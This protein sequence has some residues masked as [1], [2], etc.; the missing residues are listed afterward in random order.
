MSITANLGSSRRTTAGRIV[1]TGLTISLSFT[2]VALIVMFCLGGLFVG[3]ISLVVGLT[4]PETT[5]YSE[6]IAYTGYYTSYNIDYPNPSNYTNFLQYNESHFVSHDFPLSGH[7]VKQYDDYDIKLIQNSGNDG[8]ILPKYS[9]D[10]INHSSQIVDG[11]DYGIGTNGIMGNIAQN[12]TTSL[13]DSNGDAGNGAYIDFENM[14]IEHLEEYIFK[15]DFYI[16]VSDNTPSLYIGLTAGNICSEKFTI[17]AIDYGNYPFFLLHIDSTRIRVYVYNN[18]ASSGALVYDSGVIAST[19]EKWYSLSVRHWVDWDN[20][21]SK[22]IDYFALNV[23]SPSHSIDQNFQFGSQLRAEYLGLNN[24]SYAPQ[25]WKFFSYDSP[26]VV[27]DI[28]HGGI[29]KTKPRYCRG[30]SV[31]YSWFTDYLMEQA[32]YIRPIYQ[33][34]TLDISTIRCVG[35]VGKVV[36]PSDPTKEFL[37]FRIGTI[38]YLDFGTYGYAYDNYYHDT[39]T[40]DDLFMASQNEYHP[41]EIRALGNY[42]AYKGYRA[43]LGVVYANFTLNTSDID[44]Y[45]SYNGVTF[46]DYPTTSYLEFY[47]PKLECNISV[48][49]VSAVTMNITKS[50]VFRSAMYNSYYQTRIDEVYYYSATLP[51]SSPYN[52]VNG[53]LDPLSESKT[54]YIPSDRVLTIARSVGGFQTICI[55]LYAT[56]TLLS[57]PIIASILIICIA[58]FIVK[59]G[60]SRAPKRIINRHFAGKIQ[61]HNYRIGQK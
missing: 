49:L 50:F 25:S 26:T 53:S 11:D 18:T 32:S 47:S 56:I 10:F 43:Y 27:S 44:V 38:S 57:N 20:G 2:T 21:L 33:N 54:V 40:T 30:G 52:F 22:N 61:N 16:D 3:D 12:L 4:S 46:T 45:A 55:N 5:T 48:S 31:N 9:N 39:Y 42:N 29:Y 14:H 1:K 23:Y 60:K 13:Q 7:S 28:V 17:A 8:Y 51:S 35:A 36:F 6:Q 59:Y 19:D 41:S 58:I 34:S 37:V 15:S 24:N